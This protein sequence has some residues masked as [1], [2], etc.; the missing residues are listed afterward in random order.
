M[1]DFGVIVLFVFVNGTNQSKNFDFEIFIYNP[2][3]SLCS[4]LPFIDL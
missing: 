1:F 4:S 2:V 3:L